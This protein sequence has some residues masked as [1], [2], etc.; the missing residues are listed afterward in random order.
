M[1]IVNKVVYSKIIKVYN[2]K[3]SSLFKILLLNC[4][5]LSV[6]NWQPCE[7]LRWEQQRYSMNSS[8]GI[9]HMFQ[10]TNG[11]VCFWIICNFCIIIFIKIKNSYIKMEDNLIRWWLINICNL[12]WETYLNTFIN[13]FDDF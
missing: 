10:K 13:R 5:R 1:S 12:V 9:Q 7:L 3:R 11:A 6:R 8:T 4:M 2:N